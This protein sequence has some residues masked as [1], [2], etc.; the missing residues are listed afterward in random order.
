MATVSANGGGGGGGGVT[1]RAATA[2][3]AKKMKAVN[4]RCLHENYTLSFWESTLRAE[5]RGVSFVAVDAKDRRRVVGYCLGYRAQYG[6]DS[7]AMQCTECAASPNTPQCPQYVLFSIAVTPSSRRQGVASELLRRFLAASDE[8]QRAVAAAAAAAT[9]SHDTQRGV[10]LR[11][12][13]VVSLHVRPSNT[14]AL[15]MYERA[16][17]MLRATIAGYYDNGEDG[18]VYSRAIYPPCH[19]A[20]AAAATTTTTSA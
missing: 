1:F 13:H 2:L 14:G 11:A 15:A 16:G 18:F 9:S 5:G 10:D 7:S 8:E 4:E 19:P 17:F 20:A 3:D 12:R 6:Q